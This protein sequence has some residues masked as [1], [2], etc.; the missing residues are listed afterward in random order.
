MSPTRLLALALVLLAAPGSVA[1]ALESFAS[2]VPNTATATSS[3][4]DPL[5]CITCHNNP[6]GGAGCEPP[7]GTGT[8]PCLNPFGIQFQA[9]GYNWTP[10]LAMMDADGDGFTNGQE[11]QDPSG[12]WVFGQPSPGDDAYV[13]RPGFSTSSP[14]TT[15]ADG[16]G[17]CWYGQDLDGNG[18]CLG[19]GENN[20]EF[21]CDDMD[22]AI[23][24]SAPELCTNLVDDNCDGLDTLSDPTCSSVVDRDGDGFCPTGEDLNGDGN[25]VSS[26][27]E[28]SDAVD[29]D[30]TRITVYPGARENCTDGRDNDCNGVA[31]MDDDMCRADIDMD[32]DGFCPVGRD[33]NGDGDCLDAGEL[34][35]GFD[36]DDTNP[37]QNPDQTEICTD[38]IDND[39]DGDANFD[40]SECEGFFDEDGDGYC[41]AGQDMNGDGN[42]TGAGEEGGLVDCDDSDPLVNP[43]APEVCTDG[44]DEDCD[45]VVSLADEDCA[46]YLDADGDRYCF[47]GFD[48][49]LDGDCADMGEIGGG[50]DCRDDLADV[51]PTAT[52][53]CTDGLD[54]DCNGSFDAYDPA[55][56]TDYLDFDG[57]GWC[58][59]GQDLN[60]DGDCSDEGEQAGPADAAPNDSTV[61]P[62][63]PENCFDMKD[64]DQNGLIDLGGTF[65]VDGMD[66]TTEADPY[67]RND[68]D[69]DGDGWCPVGQDMN[70]DGDCTD[71]G[72]NIGASDCDESNPMRHPGVM[73]NLAGEDMR[74]CFNGLDDD[75]DGDV[76]LYDSECAFV[77]DRDGDG[78]CEVGADD[79]GDGDCLDFAEDRMGASTDCDDLDPSA[80]PGA[81]EVCDDGIDNDCD[82]RIDAVDPLCGGCT[83]GSC[84]DGDECTQDVCEPD[85]TCSNTPIPMCV[86]G[87]DGGLGG[88]GG[89]TGGGDDGC[90]CR[91]PGHGGSRSGGIFAMLLLGLTLLRRRR[92]H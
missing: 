25:C 32:M 56:S 44:D 71:P 75:C 69:A 4:G 26:A 14:G 34:T 49:N 1:H 23:N 53:I 51:N 54:N 65:R 29:C 16:D 70:G 28:M 43:G 89:T 57:D 47:E 19:A 6:D 2:R 40:D 63:A 90:G 60:G 83:S 78:W 18:D 13:T 55:C 27:A 8:R 82:G 15:D 48:M 35:A 61:Y 92:R 87:A 11:L 91:V 30:D 68:V 46:G 36:C 9:A 79:N 66:V 37:N 86:P 81:A 22:V 42:C 38:T 62:G 41:P 17:H 50:A 45:G 85:G 7:A 3:L 10:A 72:E 24:S 58:G 74:G 31:D 77:L 67:C 64:N 21:D 84:G 12:S 5:P 88:D 80:Y 59:V 73:E 20:G 39:C 76:D 52:E 33:L